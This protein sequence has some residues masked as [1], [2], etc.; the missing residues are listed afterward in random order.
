MSN[1]NDNGNAIKKDGDAIE[2]EFSVGMPKTALVFENGDD[3]DVEEIS[4]QPISVPTQT[5]DTA[6]DAAPV[7][8]C[9][10]ANEPILRDAD[11]DEFVI[12]ES[13]VLGEDFPVPLADD[14]TPMIW[15][16]YVPRFTE[17]SEKNYSFIDDEEAERRAEIKRAKM[18]AAPAKASAT[19]AALKK[20][21]EKH[22]KDNTENLVSEKDVTAEIDSSADVE[23]AVVVN[24]NG[25]PKQDRDTISVFKFS[26]NYEEDADKSA[27][28]DENGK[29]SDSVEKIE[30]SSEVGGEAAED[31]MPHKADRIREMPDPVRSVKEIRISQD[32]DELPKNERPRGY[33]NTLDVSDK[34]GNEYTYFTERERFKDRFLDSIMSSKLRLAV[35]AIL[36]I[37]VIA[38]E[39]I[40]IFVKTFYTDVKL[41]TPFAVGLVD[42]ILVIGL[43]ALAIPET[44]RGIARLKGG[45]VTPELS[46]I[47]S[48]AVIIA[49]TLV[50]SV[51]GE[52]QL[53][54][55]SIYAIVAVSSVFAT[56]CL[57]S[58][59]FTAFKTVSEKGDKRVVDVRFT[60]DLER[61]NM[62][63]DGTVDEY[64]SKIARD[65]KTS[66]VSSFFKNST[67]SAENHK[68]NLLMLAL[69]LGVGAVLGAVMFFI[70]GGVSPMLCSFA[71]AVTLSVPAFAIL[72]HKLPF[73]HSELELAGADCAVVGE[74]GYYDALGVDV[75]AFEDVEIFGE[76]DVTFKSVSLS[77]KRGDFRKAMRVLSQ[78]F[79]AL[80]GPLEKMLIS[81]LGKKYPA[82]E[83]VEIEDDGACGTVD[84]AV[85]MAGGAEYMQRHGIAIPKESGFSLANTKI[86][87]AAEDGE[88]FA[89]LSIQYSFS[90]EFA[91]TLSLLR[92]NGIV[93]LVY[94]R[95]PNVNNELMRFL[96]G[97]KDCIRVM[98]KHTEK[99]AEE[100]TYPALD[101][102]IATKGDKDDLIGTVLH[103]KRYA[104]FQAGVS[105]ME[106][107]AASAGAIL[108]TLISICNMTATIPSALV[109]AWHLAWCAVLF[110]MSKRSFKTRRRKKK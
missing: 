81:T 74:R 38:F 69:A 47:V 45:V 29:P 110:V 4:E 78:L 44:L 26:A 61:E 11:G 95:D 2:F 97:G 65:F 58:A 55:G 88:L 37:L 87:Y 22:E 6:A 104:G 63:L 90:E 5:A 66:F 94:S 20:T 41:T 98:K 85:V 12:P 108:A 24:T 42:V 54:L 67:K 57:H 16:T 7:D 93:P 59:D 43:F 89:R 10:E 53:L 99:P 75:I 34:G 107:T 70:G 39:N 32:G 3:A 71:I 62:A 105:L 23:G 19:E 84:G 60:R 82:A 40:N 25:K 1:I 48:A 33:D 100:K 49:Y 101:S 18:S 52:L 102:A 91:R 68:N 51:R 109:A 50:A 64:K 31:V 83:N 103:A 73:Y 35:T 36:A 96:T 46:L 17:V 8:E 13:F 30:E 21:V 86:M 80:G 79:G 9:D 72:S 56:Y 28:K 77:D 106:L 92:E 27:Q 15:T 14:G 76:D